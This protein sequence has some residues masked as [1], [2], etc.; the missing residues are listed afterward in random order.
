MKKPFT[1]EHRHSRVRGLF[2]LD[3][4]PKPNEEQIQRSIVQWLAVAAPQCL[5]MHVPNG[6]PSNPVT[7]KRFNA[8][9]LKK[10]APDLIIFTPKLVFCLEVKTETGRLTP[11]QKDVSR[12][13]N[14]LGHTYRVVRSV[15]EVADILICNN[16][17]LRDALFQGEDLCDKALD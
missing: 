9:G 1:L 2:S 5:V 16:V 3:G 6:M 17:P 8:L 11:E 15:Q 4:R 12:K 10:G 14:D 13:L 7:G